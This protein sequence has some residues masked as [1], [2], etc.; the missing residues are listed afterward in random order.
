LW[1]LVYQRLGR[2]LCSH[3]VGTDDTVEGTVLVSVSVEASIIVIAM[4][5]KDTLLERAPLFTEAQATVA[6][7]AV[8]AQAQ[9]A[10]YLDE[11][12]KLSDQELGARERA[13][14]ETNAREAVREE[15]W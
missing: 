13:W 15:P 6:L 3:L 2:A 8:E 9:L 12:T 1:P 14:A 5:A 7:R 4:T 11:E 10:D